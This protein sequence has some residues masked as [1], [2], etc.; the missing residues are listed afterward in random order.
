MTAPVASRRYTLT[1]PPD[2]APRATTRAWAAWPVLLLVI[3]AMAAPFLFV[4]LPPLTDLPN[5]LAAY[6]VELDVTHTPMLARWY[7]WSWGF[8]GNMGV[9]LA[10]WPIA[11]IVGLEPAIRLLMA[12]IPPLTA[13][14]M[15]LTAREAHGR[16]PPTAFLALP[17]VYAH[18]FQYGFLN[19]SL[20]V[21]GLFV[22][23][24]MWMR[25]GRLKRP[26]LRAAL[27][28]PGA[29][30]LLL[31][32]AVGWGL[33]MVSIGVI[34]LAATRRAKP[35]Q[36]LLTAAFRCAPLVPSALLLGVWLVA[37]G[38]NQASGFGQW[39]QKLN[40]VL[41]VLR[42]GS[43]AFDELTA[44]ALIGVL[45][46]ALC[47]VRFRFE[48][49]LGLA[50]LALVTLFLAMPAMA[51]GSAMADMR[52]TGPMLAMALLAVAPLPGGGTRNDAALALAALVLLGGRL[53]AQSQSFRTL[54]RVWTRNLGALDH[55][56]VGAR[57]FAL[58]GTECATTAPGSRLTHI[59]AMATVRRDAFVN[60]QWPS[61]KGHLLTVHYPAAQGFAL[62]PS[63]LFPLP[64][65]TGRHQTVAAILSRL[66][67]GAF[68]RV[69]LVNMPASEWPRLPWLHPVWRIDD[70]VLY[71][72]TR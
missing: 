1:V 34:E 68:D 33:A 59:P 5:H 39:H 54:D 52:I 58:A 30:L 21:A 27:F 37:G 13:A 20:S 60:G 50:A 9:E 36:G 53:V 22:A 3:A 2:T 35:V 38:G 43:P 41:T 63:D 55:V 4:T 19:F 66:P 62:S 16:L 49:R 25:L 42:N 40:A 17:L 14:G 18:A 15:L 26:R 56:P 61:D 8:S 32:H 10:I 47:G 64:S 65:C 24:G 72:V 23:V 11:R 70:A 29:V 67:R 45:A 57:V 69:W 28:V 71:R 48:R 6:R 51:L 12:A 7:G 31:A 46:I 44:L